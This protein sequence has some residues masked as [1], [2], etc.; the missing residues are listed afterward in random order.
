MET[1]GT[2]SLIFRILAADSSVT[3]SLS[4]G[5]FSDTECSLLM[6]FVL[7]SIYK[8]SRVYRHST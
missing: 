5:G 2:V 7:G 4:N 6:V 1:S 8:F 3:Q